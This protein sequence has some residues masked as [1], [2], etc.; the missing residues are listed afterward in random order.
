MQISSINHFLLWLKGLGFPPTLLSWNTEGCFL[1]FFG[2]NKLVSLKL[3]DP[4]VSCGK[5]SRIKTGSGL[6]QARLCYGLRREPQ[7]FTICWRWNRVSAVL[8]ET[9]LLK[10][11][12]R[13]ACPPLRNNQ[14]IKGA[15]RLPPPFNGGSQTGVWSCQQVQI[16][17]DLHIWLT[18]CWLSL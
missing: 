1:L 3:A 8:R 7:T 5:M 15:N 6:P 2:K 13:P 10:A 11:A 14:L 12:L 18:C 4:P 9:F 16:R 17:L